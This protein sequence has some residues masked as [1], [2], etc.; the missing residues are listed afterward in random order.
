MANPNDNLEKFVFYLPMGIFS[1]ASILDKN[2]F[3]AEIIHLELESDK[4]I[5]EILDFDTV[6]AVGFSCHWSN[7]GRVVMD[8]AG[9]IKNCKPDIFLF[10]GGYTA[11][12][13]AVEILEEYSTV[14]AVIRGDAEIP[15]VELCRVLH[16]HLLKNGK[17]FTNPAPL[18][19]GRVKNLVW[20]GTDGGVLENEQ[21]YVSTA[22][23]LER[24]DFD[25]IH[26]LR[27]WEH[28]LSVGK[29][30]TKSKAINSYS[31]FLLEV[32]RGCAYNCSFCGGNAYAQVCI[33]RRNGQAV[34]S[35]DSVI[36]SIKKAMSFG[37]ECFFAC[38]QFEGSDQWYMKLFRRIKEEKL[39]VCFA[40]ESWS[41][42]SKELVDVMSECCEE[43]TYTISPDNGNQELRKRNKD[44]RLFYTNRQL[45]TCLDHI[46]TKENVNV[47]LYFGYFVPF[48]REDDVYETMSYITKLFCKYSYF[49]AIAYMPFTTD[50]C[51]SIYFNPEKYD[52]H[53][54]VHDF[55]DF[56][57][58]LKINFELKNGKVPGMTLLSRPRGMTDITAVN[59]A[60]KINLFNSLFYFRESVLNLLSKVN[61]ATLFSDYFRTI[62][63]SFASKDDFTL[64]K[65]KQV[66]L[67]ICREQN[68]LGEMLDIIEREYKSNRSLSLSDNLTRFYTLD[69]EGKNFSS[70]PNK[71]KD[72]GD[73]EL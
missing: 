23:D 47:Q 55:K 53:L 33:N 50:I 46:A 54:S 48:E 67:D 52:F 17:T 38:F 28:Y 10:L 24:F 36:A 34:R 13:F 14:D 42:L 32:G 64:N 73:F 31:M 7:Q 63:L 59:L 26:L 11:S 1:L 56:V 62:N 39:K 9:L 25:E 61:T 40:Y 72:D 51:S 66:F 30:W 18:F 41:V 8:N 45:E 68:I 58:K 21:L 20:R 19:Q 29:Y 4:K 27:N 71:I 44:N 2:G 69:S 57:R 65:I 6:D 37:I 60:N 12:F 3:D 5:D 43:V 35:V 49:T 16:E 15:I 22:Q 70:I